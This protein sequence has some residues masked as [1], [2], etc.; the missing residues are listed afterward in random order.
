MPGAASLS[1]ALPFLP[2]LVPLA[3]HGRIPDASEGPRRGPA[4]APPAAAPVGPAVTLS[5]LAEALQALPVAQLRE[6]AG[7]RRK[8]GKAEA[9]AVIC[10]MPI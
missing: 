8:C 3:R 6:M 7:I 4:A 5:G 2:V 9:V 10:A 1:E